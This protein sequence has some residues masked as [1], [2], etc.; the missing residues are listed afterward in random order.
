MTQI[1]LIVLLLLV[2]LSVRRILRQSPLSKYSAQQQTLM[3]LGILLILLLVFTGRLGLL[4]PLLGAILAA[5]FAVISRLLPLLIPLIL[6]YLP[7]WRR[8]RH[9]NSASTQTGSNANPPL[10]TI[11]TSHLRMR[12]R[13]D[14][15]ELSGEILLGL[16]TGRR[17]NELNLQELADLYR[18]YTRDDPES[19]RLLEGY[20]ERQYGDRWQDAQSQAHPES[21]QPRMDKSEALE[22][23]GLPPDARRE[24]IIAAHRRLIQ[25][26]HPDRGGSD[27]L[28]AKIN[29]AKDLLLDL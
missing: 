3:A 24:D 14:T 1:I 21:D 26:V 2:V 7:Y 9:Q 18:I 11:D 25:K 23:L 15:G 28:A 4:I 8:Y 12:L 17:L 20:M 6:Q 5:V 13:H 22:I 16:H 27:Y 29:Q 19:A 10:S